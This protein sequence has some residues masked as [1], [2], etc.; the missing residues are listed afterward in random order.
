MRAQSTWFLDKWI[1]AQM[2]H[3][4]DPLG[5]FHPSV[6]CDNFETTITIGKA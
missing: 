2:V 6:L 1:A 5:G 4:V 3:Y